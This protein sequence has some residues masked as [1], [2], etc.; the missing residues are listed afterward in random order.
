MEEILEIKSNEEALQVLTRMERDLTYIKINVAEEND[1]DIKHMEETIDYF[2][3]RI[4]KKL[5][6]EYKQLMK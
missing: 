2:S 5:E 1:K 4:Q 6:K 3:F